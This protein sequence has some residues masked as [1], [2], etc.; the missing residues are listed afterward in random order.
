M[1]SKPILCLLVIC[2]LI[3]SSGIA[4]A[5]SYPY[6][7]YEELRDG[8]SLVVSG[9]VISISEHKWYTPSGEKPAGVFTEEGVDENGPYTIIHND[10][11]RDEFGYTDFVL[12][13]NTVYR[14]DLEEDEIVIRLIDSRG[15]GNEPSLSIRSYKEGDVY[16][17][18]LGQHITPDGENVPNHYCIIT[19]RGSLRKQENSSANPEIFVNFYGDQVIP[20]ILFKDKNESKYIW[21]FGIIFAIAAV[22]GLTGFGLYQRRKKQ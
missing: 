18:F 9:Q 13:V 15:M 2:L 20:E 3:L 22:A 19:P 5:T 1:K 16:L 4:S 7:S 21:G 11:K 12:K 17:L 14:G 10:L 6:Y 8:C